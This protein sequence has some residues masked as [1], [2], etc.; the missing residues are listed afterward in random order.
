MVC[1]MSLNR[2]TSVDDSVCTLLFVCVSV[3]YVT[4]KSQSAVV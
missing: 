4:S 3:C 2:T 1:M